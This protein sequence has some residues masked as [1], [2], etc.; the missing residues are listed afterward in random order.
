MK[1]E[2][3]KWILA[4][5]FLASM[6]TACDRQEGP[7]EEAGESIDQAVEEAGDKTED[8]L[9]RAGDAVEDATDGNNP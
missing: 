6:I 3:L 4:A 2:S 1:L 9:E 8:T 7:M 5:G